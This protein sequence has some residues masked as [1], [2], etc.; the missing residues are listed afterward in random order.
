[1]KQDT[2]I[3]IIQTSPKTA[4]FADNAQEI[5]C[6]Y[7]KCV[8]EGAQLVIAPA[9]SLAGHQ[10]LDL[11]YNTSFLEHNAHHLRKLAKELSEVPLILASYSHPLL[12]RSLEE[13]KDDT[14]DPCQ[15][16]NFIDSRPELLPY[17]LH[18]GRATQLI[19]GGINKI[20]TMN[21]FLSLG[22]EE[23][24]ISEIENQEDDFDS[25]LDGLDGL[26]DSDSG[27]TTTPQADLIIRLSTTP[28]H[29]RAVP[30]H[31]HSC[32]WE[33]RT[34]NCPL[35]DIHSTGYAE[36]HCYEGGSTHYSRHGHATQRLAYFQTDAAVI[37][38]HQSQ[39]AAELPDETELLKHCLET[40]LREYT[41]SMN[42]RGI[43]INR[44]IDNS[45]LL[46]QIA[47]SALG[48]EHVHSINFSQDAA[49]KH[50]KIRQLA[51][52][53]THSPEAQKN[54][55][56]NIQSVL[57]RAYA[58]EQKLLLISPLSC[59]N[60]MLG[61][62]AQ[63]HEACATFLPLG[64]IYSKELSKLRKLIHKEEHQ[65]ASSQAEEHNKNTDLVIHQIKDL[66]ES[67][68][69]IIRFN[70][71]RINESE[72]RIIQKRSNRAEEGKRLLPPTLHIKAPYARHQQPLCYTQYD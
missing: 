31:E 53:I 49:D 40:S 12:H 51:Q 23:H 69:N 65:Q 71:N 19:D 57:I 29:L 35:I 16:D 2:P 32:Q 67:M 72:I 30:M 9:L 13:N 7:N 8:Q 10:V 47:I 43:C 68:Q 33:A 24:I 15:L 54:A 63:E 42:Y 58:K 59:H 4:A 62:Y 64:E 27:E 20:D 44:D 38:L 14:S 56:Q 11:C 36:H 28:W 66:N 6:A 39:K 46:T 18:Q 60:I 41:H 21:I 50:E 22:E 61:Q 34:N 5:L 52:E 55:Q 17:L 25:D 45:D 1:M 3:G 48:K 37:Q 70:I 26:D